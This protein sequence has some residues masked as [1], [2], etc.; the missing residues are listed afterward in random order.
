MHVVGKK[1][2]ALA[3]MPDYLQKIAATSTKAKQLA[4]Q[5]IASQYLLHLQ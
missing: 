2:C 4:A 1:A 5:R 3:V